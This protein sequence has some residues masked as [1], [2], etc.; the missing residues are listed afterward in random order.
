[1]YLLQIRINLIEK[2]SQELDITKK[3]FDSSP[4]TFQGL[5]FPSH[6]EIDIKI[7]M[8]P[9]ELIELMGTILISL[10]KEKL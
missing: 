4:N 5:K 2:F 1:M 10:L 6:Q 3:V 8:P 7:V 9:Y